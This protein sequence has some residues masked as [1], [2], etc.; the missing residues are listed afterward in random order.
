MLRLAPGGG[1]LL[2]VVEFTLG[3]FRNRLGE[4]CEFWDLFFFRKR[5][6]A[7]IVSFGRYIMRLRMGMGMGMWIW[8]S[9]GERERVDSEIERSVEEVDESVDLD[10]EMKMEEEG[11]REEWMESEWKGDEAERTLKERRNVINVIQKEVS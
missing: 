11:E 2:L 8:I 7:L 1:V 4:P 6:G 10:L 9:E 5:E 3:F